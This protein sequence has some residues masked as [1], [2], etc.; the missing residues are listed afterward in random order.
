MARQGN[1]SR[2]RNAPLSAKTGDLRLLP[3]DFLDLDIIRKKTRRIG[4]MKYIPMWTS[5]LFLVRV[6]LSLYFL[7]RR[8][9]SMNSS[10]A[11]ISFWPARFVLSAM[12]CFQSGLLDARSLFRVMQ[13]SIRRSHCSGLAPCSL[14]MLT[15]WAISQTRSISNNASF[16]LK[17]PGVPD[18]SDGSDGTSYPLMENYTPLVA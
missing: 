18:S 3:H 6:F 16:H 10:R 2:H 17:H 9:S 1:R 14:M 12:Y 15:D 7:W 13:P 4:A 8:P 5:F 11:A